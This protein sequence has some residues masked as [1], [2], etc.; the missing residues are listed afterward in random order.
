MLKRLE[1]QYRVTGPDIDCGIDD[2]L[3]SLSR[4]QVS[5]NVAISCPR[6]L[7]ANSN[8]NSPAK[9]RPQSETSQKP[10]ARRVAAGRRVPV[11]TFKS[12]SWKYTTA[13]EPRRLAHKRT[14]GRFSECGPRVQ[15]KPCNDELLGPKRPRGKGLTWRARDVAIAP[16]SASIW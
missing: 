12:K 7:V 6:L 4:T 15:M 9:A 11:K 3:R 16:K 13:A 5:S 8:F 1:F 14:F 10:A 2:S